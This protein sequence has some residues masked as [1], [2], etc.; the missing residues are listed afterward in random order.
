MLVAIP[1]RHFNAFTT[2]NLTR[3]QHVFPCFYHIVVSP[4]G[5]VVVV[6]S[7]CI[8]LKQRMNLAWVV[9]YPRMGKGM[10]IFFITDTCVLYTLLCFSTKVYYNPF[11]LECATYAYGCI[12]DTKYVLYIAVL[13]KLQKSR[14]MIN[15]LR[16]LF[17]ETI[18]RLRA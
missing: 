6:F 10:H 16:G 14:C 12:H 11:I 8:G 5:L 15:E 9:L 7:E 1:F 17:G 4:L 18:T 3:S 2:L 13:M